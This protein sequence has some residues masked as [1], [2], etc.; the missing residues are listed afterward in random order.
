MTNK[1]NIDDQVYCIIDSEVV[2]GFIYR[3]LLDGDF[4]WYG[5]KGK[6]DKIRADKVFNTKE[7]LLK[8]L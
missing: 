8:S 1:F 5:I 6:T 2:L 3:I 4:I 7:E